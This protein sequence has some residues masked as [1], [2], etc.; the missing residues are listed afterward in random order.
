MLITQPSLKM[1]TSTSTFL[2]SCQGYRPFSSDLTRRGRKR[3]RWRGWWRQVKIR[4]WRSSGFFIVNFEQILHLVLVFPLL[5]LKKKK[6]QLRLF[7]CLFWLEKLI[8]YCERKTKP[9]SEKMGNS[10]TNL[11]IIDNLNTLLTN[12]TSMLSVPITS[13]RSLIFLKDF[14]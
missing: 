13:A 3:A 12:V 5:S 10:F 2:Q 8:L 9:K 4:Q 1:K 6:Y 7:Q 11:I 14:H